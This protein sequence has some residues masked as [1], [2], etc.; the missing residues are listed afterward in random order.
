MGK[1]QWDSELRVQVRARGSSSSFAVGRAM[2][3]P[4][5]STWRPFRGCAGRK[6]SIIRVEFVTPKCRAE[7]WES[8]KTQQA[9][10]AFCQRTLGVAVSQSSLWFG[11]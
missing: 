1:A 2:P 6:F 10:Q 5:H 9:A 4:D 3:A 7:N 11:T 8:C